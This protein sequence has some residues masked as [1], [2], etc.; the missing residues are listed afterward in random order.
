MVAAAALLLLLLLLI[1]LIHEHVSFLKRATYRT[2]LVGQGRGVSFSRNYDSRTDS[3]DAA[4]VGAGIGGMV[5]AIRL[6]QG[7]LKTALIEKQGYLGGRCGSETV[8]VDLDSG[9]AKVNLQVLPASNISSA[10]RFDVGP[11]LL[12]LPDVYRD[13]FQQMNASL[14]SM[15]DLIAVQP[16]YRCFF[17]ED[18]TYMDLTS[19][20]LLMESQIEAIEPGAWA[21][22][23]LYMRTA[24]GFLNFGLPGNSSPRQD[25][26]R[27]SAYHF[28]CTVLN[29]VH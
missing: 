29:S 24:K 27:P 14:D 16:F 19:D 11:S 21:Q 2:V 4:V 28:T 17:E 18:C 10:F 5:T 15:V 9:T 6:S 12:L 7:G 13:V 22:F 26:H 8:L 23:Q 1:A 3:Y 25:V 20:A